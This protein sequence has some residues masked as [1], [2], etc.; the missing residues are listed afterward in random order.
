MNIFMVLTILVINVIAV[1]L[2]YQFIKTL[3]KK[4]K[5]IFIAVT[6][7]INYILVSIIYWLSSL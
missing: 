2:V 7:A 4:E 1:L 6:I 5:I 3:E